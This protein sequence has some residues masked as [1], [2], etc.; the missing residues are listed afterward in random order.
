MNINYKI[1]I[2]KILHELIPITEKSVENGNKIFGALILNKKDYSTITIDTNNE[3]IN[4]LFHGE[5]STINSFFKKNLSINPTD[6]F[7]VSSHEP[8]SLCLSAI[9]WC[10]F[11]NF[12]YLFPYE[13]TENKFNIPHDLK[14]LKEIFNVKNG[15]YIKKNKYWKSYS[16]INQINLLNNKRK[17]ELNIDI[18][19]IYLIYEKL[20][21]LYQKYKLNN[22]IP[23]K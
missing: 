13:S 7:F 1:I 21:K 3:I 6:C 22:K 15:K 5:I 17:K 2:D 18:E 19:R 8:C 12:I 10:G 20:S 14:I 4:P 11:D 16:I 23:L 9:T